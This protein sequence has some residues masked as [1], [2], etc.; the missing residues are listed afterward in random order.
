VIPVE[1]ARRENLSTDIKELFERD[2]E[3]VTARAALETMDRNA[4]KKTRRLFAGIL[5]AE[6]NNVPAKIGMGMLK[7]CPS[8][9]RTLSRE[10][11]GNATSIWP[12]A[13]RGPS[14]AAP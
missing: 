2:R 8:N 5:S 3:F 11:R 14:A 7:S 9:G 4:V 10:P 12:C 1:A 6:P 13:S